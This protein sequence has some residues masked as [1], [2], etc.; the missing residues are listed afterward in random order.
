MAYNT[1][2]PEM[3][4]TVQFSG[5]GII[6]TDDDAHRVISQGVDD[7]GLGRW[8][9]L[10]LEGKESHFLHVVSAYRPVANFSHGPSTVH[11]Q[12]EC[13]LSKQDRDKEPR[14]TFYTDLIL[15]VATWKAMGDLIVIGIDAN[16]DVRQG[17]TARIFSKMALREVILELHHH[18][19]PPATC[20]KNN[21]REPIDGL[22]ASPG[23]RIVAGGYSPFNAGCPSDH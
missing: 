2:E 20:D 18:K 4:T 17:G 23:V 6:A 3:T 11:A 7:S 22:F 13:F 1:T 9:W 21:N 12:H 14:N 15:A 10:H 19:L 16:E 5:V 8:S